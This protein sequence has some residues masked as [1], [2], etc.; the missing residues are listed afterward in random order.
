MYIDK[1]TKYIRKHRMVLSISVI[2][3]LLLF[4]VRNLYRFSARDYH[5]K[6]ENLRAYSPLDR[7]VQV[8]SYLTNLEIQK[9]QKEQDRID[10][11]YCGGPC[12]FINVLYVREQGKI[13]LRVVVLHIIVVLIE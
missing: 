5:V 2:S 9:L 13:K 8:A 10:F 4:T 1:L 12:R 7:A 6:H 3:V 11:K